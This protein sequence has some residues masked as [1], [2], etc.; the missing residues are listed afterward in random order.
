LGSGAVL[1]EAELEQ[2]DGITAGTVTASKAVV[3]DANKDIASF[4]N[5]TLTG[6]LDAGSLDI[7]G[8][9]DID[10]TLE[11]DAMTLNGSAITT[12]ATLSTGI[13]NGNVL[14]ATS[15]VAD[16]DFLRVDGT[17]IEGRSASEVLSDIGAS[18]VAGSSSI[19]TTGALDSGS[20]TSG[21]G[22]I[23]TG[24]STI[25]TTGAVA[26]GALTVTGD[27]I[28][29]DGS[30]NLRINDTDT[31]RFIDIL[32]G[33]R[34]ATFRNTMASGEDMDTVAPEIIFQTKDDGETREHFR[35]NKS[36]SVFNEG[37]ADLDFRVESNDNANMLVVDAG[38]NSV[39]IGTS[40]PNND[41][42][43]AQSQTSFAYPDGGAFLEIARTSGADAGIIINKNTGQYVIGI[44]NSDGTNPP[45]RIEYS[46]GGSAVSAL[47]S[48]TLGF[49]VSSSGGITL[50][51]TGSANTLDSYEEGSYD[52]AVT[53]T[54]G[55]ITLNSSFKSA[56][57]TKVGR[58]VHVNGLINVASVSS[59]T[60][61]VTI[62]LPFTP[63][64]LSQR[65]GDSTT[66][67]YITGVV[68][69]NVSD[70][71]TSINE[72]FA[73]FFIQLGDTNSPVNDAGEQIQAGVN[74][75]FSASYH[76]A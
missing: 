43:I 50:G 38:T 65:R 70:F 68:S 47:G 17:S 28:L 75:V 29:N 27:V 20:I 44:D 14:V 2:L 48:G 71:V 33:T 46:A 30:P 51:G 41:L 8:D 72:G 36:E 62:S 24:S 4:R 23:D 66:S 3:V 76:T 55:S 56:S 67:L 22:N 26:T 35:M 31:S 54:N 6:E 58:L 9:A 61:V 13:S 7:S 42:V 59:P 34:N 5:I 53:P 63:V 49:G 10:G 39:G 16:N 69:N 64:D 37:S 11:A 60:G 40:S 25:T 73:G 45:L 57:Y 52:V 1:S 21:F 74:F 19:V 15:G 18:P 32:Y 12:T